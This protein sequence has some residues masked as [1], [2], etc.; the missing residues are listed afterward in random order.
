MSTSRLGALVAVA[1]RV[2]LGVHARSQGCLSLVGVASL[3]LELLLDCALDSSSRAFREVIELHLLI[4][5]VVSL[6]A[7]NR[8]LSPVC[9]LELI[10]LD[11]DQGAAIQIV[12]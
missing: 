2:V 11:L 4:R 6:A 10:V 7:Q 9:L 5:A 8:T 12:I 1:N 3:S